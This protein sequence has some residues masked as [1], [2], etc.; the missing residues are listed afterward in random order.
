MNH[1]LRDLYRHVSV[2]AT[3]DREHEA[4]IELLLLVM[5]ADHHITDDEIDEIRDISDDSGWEIDD[6]LVRPVPRPGDGQGAH[7]RGRPRHRRAA[8]R[9]RRPRHQHRAAPSLF[10]ARPRR[11]RRRSRH[12][13]GGRVTPRSDRRPLRL[14]VRPTA[15]GRRRCGRGRR[16]SG[17]MRRRR[18]RPAARRAASATAAPWPVPISSTSQPPGATTGGAR[19]RCARTSSRPSAP[20]NSATCGSQSRTIGSTAG[21]RRRCTAGWRRRRRAAAQRVGQRVEPRA[22][23]EAHRWPRHARCRRGW[24]GRRRARRP[25]ASVS[26][27]SSRRRGPSSVA[28]DSP[29]APLPVPRSAQRDRARQRDEPAAIAASATSSVSGRG[30]STRRSTIRSRWRN[31]QWPSTYCSGSPRA[32]RA[33]IASRWATTARSPARRARRGTRR[34]RSPLAFSHSQR[35]C[36]RPMRAAGLVPQLAPGDRA[37]HSSPAASWRARSSAASASTTSSRSPASTSCSR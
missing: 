26:H 8:R 21:R 2:H 32:S 28:S 6:V 35:A 36:G 34:R 24:P 18:S 14:S 15:G 25:T 31:D 30:I 22:V 33:S 11:G 23:G 9:H 12:R 17:S 37:A 19:R 16:R 5:M 4:V 10:S 13:P 3:A 27:T 7:R 20:A 1:R 29:I